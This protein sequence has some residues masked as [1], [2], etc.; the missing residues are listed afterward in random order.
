VTPEQFEAYLRY[1]ENCNRG[2]LNSNIPPCRVYLDGKEV[3][4]VVAVNRKKGVLRMY[5]FPIRVDKWGKKILQH[6]LYGRVTLEE[7]K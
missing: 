4:N 7:I 2:W 5:H 6:T 1:V 3:K